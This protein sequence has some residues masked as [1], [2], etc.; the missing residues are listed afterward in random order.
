MA[1][2]LSE[3]WTNG[4]LNTLY[5]ARDLGLKK[6]D[7]HT[8]LRIKRKKGKTTSNPYAEYLPFR[9]RRPQATHRTHQQ[10]PR[11]ANKRD[12]PQAL[13]TPSRRA[14]KR[15]SGVLEGQYQARAKKK[16]QEQDEQTIT[17]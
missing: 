11:E 7:I 1:K 17:K 2:E 16:Q 8:D 9:S 13:I 4:T 6:P 10:R 14:E 3:E 15:L 12:P 5:V